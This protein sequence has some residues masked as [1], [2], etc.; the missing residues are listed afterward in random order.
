MTT[1]LTLMK[2][3]KT[4]VILRLIMT[5]LVVFSI[6]YVGFCQDS[7][8]IDNQYAIDS[9]ILKSVY[10]RRLQPYIL[11][12][13]LIAAGS[14]TYAIKPFREL[15]YGIRHTINDLPKSRLEIDDY[16]Q[17][18]PAAMVYGLNLVGLKGKHGFWDRTGLLASSQ[19]ITAAFVLP[20]KRIIGRTRPDY[21]DNY[22]FPSGHAA[23][24]FTSAHFLFKEYRDTNF[25]LSVSGYPIAIFTS[26]FRVVESRHWVSDIVTG[27]GIGILSTELAYLLYP[28]AI[29][30]IGKKQKHRAFFSPSIGSKTVGFTF[31]KQF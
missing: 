22:S 31:S 25:W 26:V 24:A 3:T 10:K 12:G 5:T 2:R 13:S 4:E 1:F 29:K 9:T 20:S 16:T 11:S 19:M 17:F 18:V 30:L 7:T 6:S 14:I 23:V 27:A 15:D 8:R 28:K 21:S